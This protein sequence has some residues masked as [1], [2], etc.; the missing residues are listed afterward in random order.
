MPTFSRFFTVSK[1]IM[2]GAVML[3]FRMLAIWDWGFRLSSPLV[4]VW[5]HRNLNWRGLSFGFDLSGKELLRIRKVS[6]NTASSRSRG[7][8]IAAEMRSLMDWR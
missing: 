1:L 8:S 2:R 4:H 7:G 5:L 3:A 6:K